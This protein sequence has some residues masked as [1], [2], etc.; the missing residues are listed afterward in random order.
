MNK[1]RLFHDLEDIS[2]L[3]VDLLHFDEIFEEGTLY[4]SKRFEVRALWIE[5]SPQIDADT[6][7][8][9]PNLELV[10]LSTT[11]NTQVDMK[12]LEVRGI[13]LI[14]LKDFPDLMKGITSTAELT[15]AL[16][17]SVWRKI[18]ILSTNKGELDLSKRY[19]NMPTQL[20]GKSLGI[21][22]FGRVGQQISHYGKAFDL[23]IQYNDPYLNSELKPSLDLAI[24]EKTLEELLSTSD[25]IVLSA[26]KYKNTSPII[27]RNNFIHVK[28][29]S[30]LINTARGSLWDEEQVV[31][32]LISGA[33]SG[34]G[35]DVFQCEEFDM[36]FRN[37]SELLLNLDES[38]YNIIR[39]SHIGGATSDA[40]S[41]VTKKIILEIQSYF[42]GEK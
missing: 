37:Q 6:L 8:V 24:T 27:N 23:K 1:D 10:A 14:S 4:H 5:F 13:K 7:D 21:I 36:K 20:A 41:T 28:P 18:K 17:L 22:G 3:K 35:V 26:S 42:E 29:N 39:T 30:I 19:I 15:W 25:I 40:L 12:E 11:S 34:V 31:A 9:F 16:V 33:I 32:G 38:K 2:N